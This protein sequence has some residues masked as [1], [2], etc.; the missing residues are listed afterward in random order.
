MTE[1]PVTPTLH[2]Y[3]LTMLSDGTVEQTPCYCDEHFLGVGRV[4]VPCGDCEC[5]DVWETHLGSG[6][7]DRG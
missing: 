7:A 2:R 1:Q 3:Q 6:E 4:Q 5:C